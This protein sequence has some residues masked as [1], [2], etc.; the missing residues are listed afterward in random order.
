VSGGRGRGERGSV[1][2][3]AAMLVPV[4][5]VLVSLV[6]AAGRIRTVD[7]VVVEAS[8]DA[9]RAASMAAPGSAVA[10]GQR[11]GDDTLSSQGLTCQVSVV[12]HFVVGPGQVGTVQ[13]TVH[14][15]VPLSDL[16]WHGLPGSVPVTD[17]FT[18]VVDVY[19][20]R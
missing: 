20:S 16:L 11:A 18:A 15:T 9:A 10:A 17:S 7:G 14:C 8:R 2:I 3:E 19:R 5:I 13:A 4:F 6:V 12:P 1:A